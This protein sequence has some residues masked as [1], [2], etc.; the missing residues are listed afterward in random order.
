MLRTGV[1]ERRGGRPPLLAAVATRSPGSLWPTVWLRS[2]ITP[3][4]IRKAAGLSLSLHDDHYLPV[5][6]HPFEFMASF[7]TAAF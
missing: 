1:R 2:A 6:A 4:V 7:L 3:C 5:G